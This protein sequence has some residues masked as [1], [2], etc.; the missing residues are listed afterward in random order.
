MG[1]L[2][3]P[4]V[5]VKEIDLTNVIPALSTSIGGFAGRFKWGPAE[6]L[7]T[8]SSENDLAGIFGKPD[9]S[10]AKVFL[11]AAGFLKYGNTL[12][13]SRAVE[14][15]TD[16][17][18]GATI[19]ASCGNGGSAPTGTTQNI[20]IKNLTDWE[21][22]NSS[23]DTSIVAIARCPG[24]YGNTLQV[25]IARTSSSYGAAS[26]EIG[27]N[28]GKV[29]NGKVLVR[30]N[31]DAAPTNAQ[32][33]GDEIHVLV[34]DQDGQL[35]GQKN[36]VI[37]KY[38]GLSLCKDA[39]NEDGSSNYYYDVIN[40]TSQFIF[41]NKLGSL[42]TNSDLTIAAVEAAGGA[43]AIAD[44]ATDEDTAAD[45]AFGGGLYIDSLTKGA[46]GTID[47]G[48]IG[49]ALD[50]FAD[51]ETVDVNL[52]FAEA[53]ALG[54]TAQETVDIKLGTI[55]NARKDV[56]SFISAPVGSSGSAS[57][58]EGLTTESA[59]LTAVTTRRNSIT[60]MSSYTFMDSSPLYVYNKYD[61]NYVYIAASGHMAG[62]CVNTDNVAE[63]WF[64]PAGFNRGNLQGV[65][66]LAFNPNQS[67]RDTLYK[68]QVNPLA[69]FPGQG[70]VLYGDKTGQVK[71]S[72]FDR[73]NV[74]RL[75]ITLEKAI[76]T[77]SKFQLFELN[78]EFTRAQFRNLVEPFLRDVKGRR[79]ITDFL[80]VCDETNNTGQVIDTN[81]F[82]ADI[83]IKPARS[84]NFITLNFV[85]TRTGVDF[86]EVVGS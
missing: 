28:V 76:S 61:D 15:K 41:I 73:I 85:A 57:A 33:T 50:L 42:Y 48:G 77:A 14:D 43:G 36:N 54:D 66:K 72:A 65:V 69:A 64:S 70:I 80:V 45:G 62:L 51:T 63:S 53:G 2:V 31:F 30:D 44:A 59:K 12:K 78:D 68:A 16:F 9:A 13:I 1:F 24:E 6:E 3:S 81:R 49:T 38:Q 5:E 56:V 25:V 82:V 39:K 11:Q 84:I 34:I 67:S 26:D 20:L 29:V 71:A 74:R 58:I 22:T 83:Y 32:S 47:A 8:V 23:I 19:S 17:A 7:T 52:L 27:A 35:S 18:S 79:G 21:A 75:F 46:D 4:G 40:N 37:E 60:T 55:A 10:T 86:S